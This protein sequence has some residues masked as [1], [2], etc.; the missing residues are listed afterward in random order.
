MI[1]L[2]LHGPARFAASCSDEFP[3]ASAI[4]RVAPPTKVDRDNTIRYTHFKITLAQCIHAQQPIN[5]NRD[6]IVPTVRHVMS[7]R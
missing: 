5:G 6:S 4:A 1:S 2:E 7:L 3:T